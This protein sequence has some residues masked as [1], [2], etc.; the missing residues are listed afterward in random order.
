MRL[1][2]HLHFDGHCETAF[3]Y[4]ETC[5]GGK[6]TFM[7]RYAETPAGDKVQPEWRNKIIHATIVVDD[8]M[9]QG[10]DVPVDQY[11]KPQGFSV[12]LHLEDLAK[13][14]RIFNALA[15]GGEVMMRFQETFWARGFGMLTDRFGI[16]WMIN[17]ERQT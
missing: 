1:N 13:A 15:E 9:L 7:M 5:L 14:E 10:A 6:I 17:V 16:P 12:T 2:P 11:R 4:Y 8:Y 3:K